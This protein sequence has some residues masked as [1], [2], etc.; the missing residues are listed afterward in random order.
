MLTKR[1]RML[2]PSRRRDGSFTR[3]GARIITGC[4]RQD[5][6]VL[7]LFV[8]VVFFPGIRRQPRQREKERLEVDRRSSGLLRC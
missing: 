5:Q 7:T 6:D 2:W 8:E 4:S 3:L 1:T